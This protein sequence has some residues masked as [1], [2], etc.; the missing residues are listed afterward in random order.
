MQPIPWNVTLSASADSTFTAAEF[1]DALQNLGLFFIASAEFWFFT[2][3][4]SEGVTNHASPGNAGR[5]SLL[6]AGPYSFKL[7][8]NAV[9]K[10]RRNGSTPCV[11]NGIVTSL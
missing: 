9:L 2:G 4:W 10:F 1:G 6:E 7:E 8:D 5:G 11:L 3:A